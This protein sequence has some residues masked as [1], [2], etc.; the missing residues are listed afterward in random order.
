MTSE[1]IATQVQSEQR[2]LPN[3]SNP[4]RK[5]I[6]SISIIGLLEMRPGGKD[7]LSKVIV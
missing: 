4:S 1:A 5:I 7:L 6:A 3:I 2:P